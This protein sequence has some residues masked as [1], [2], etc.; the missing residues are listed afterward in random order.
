M[1]YEFA[2][3]V[4]N[5]PG[6]YDTTLSA[7]SGRGVPAANLQTLLSGERSVRALDVRGRWTTE[8]TYAEP[9]AVVL[10]TA[11]VGACCGP[12]SETDRA[13]IVTR[14][15]YDALGRRDS[16]TRDGVRLRTVF[17]AAGRPHFTY[18]GQV[19]AA[20]TLIGAEQLIAQNTYDTAG[21]LIETRDAANRVT[22]ILE[23][24]DAA[25]VRKVKRTLPGGGIET[26]IYHPDGTLQAV[27]DTGDTAAHPRKYEY[28]LVEN[29]ALPGGGTNARFTKEIRLREGG[30]ET[31]WTKTYSDMLGRTCRIETA[32]GTAGHPTTYEYNAAGQLAKVTDPDGVTML[33]AY[34][35]EGEREIEALD[36]PFGGN[37]NGV[38]DYAGTDRIVKRVASVST[39]GTATVRRVTTSQWQQDDVDAATVISIEDR[40]PNGLDTWS[41]SHGL[42]TESHTVQAAGVSTTTTTFPDLST[43]IEVRDHG[44]LTSRTRK[45]SGAVTIEKQTY[46]YADP[47]KRLTSVTDLRNGATD[48]TYYADDQIET[49][50]SPDP[51]GAGPLARLVTTTFYDDAGRKEREVQPD[52]GEVSFTWWPTGELKSTSGARTYPV[53]YTYDPQGRLKT[54]T[55]RQG[56]PGVDEAV[57]TWVYTSA[58]LLNHKE[59]AETTGPSYTRTVG[60]DGRP[61][62]SGRAASPP[63]TRRT[64]PGKSPASATAAIPR[65]APPSPTTGAACRRPSPTPAAAA[66]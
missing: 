20:G 37:R 31:E 46:A 7:G 35:A 53:S 42:L 18:R 19:D 30:A 43:L 64:M 10:E 57:T 17:D 26:E 16:E 1:S 38:I 45:D 59:Y 63:P 54:L 41:T 44:R 3:R 29:L 55:T 12:T 5:V 4:M 25:G 8:T 40:T 11:T 56:A 27:G 24:I 52:T 13:G 32:Q 48:F 21:R 22:T 39:R 34:N 6:P 28:G 58:G 47:F 2:D 62:G 65:P 50:T 60:L 61:R 9:G 51:D 14:F 66:R 36:M 23:T 15:T 49:V 33:Y